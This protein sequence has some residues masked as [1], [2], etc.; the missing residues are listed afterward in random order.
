VSPFRAASHFGQ[1]RAKQARG[2]RESCSGGE[3]EPAT[4]DK[5]VAAIIT[6]AAWHNRIA[7]AKK[8]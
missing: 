5:L 7:L 4:F 8:L 1:D 6:L 3:E 2:A